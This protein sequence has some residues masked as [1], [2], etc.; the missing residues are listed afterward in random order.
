MSV[1]SI[2]HRSRAN[3]VPTDTIPTGDREAQRPAARVQEMSKGT[4]ALLAARDQAR[5]QARKLRAEQT[6]AAQSPDLREAAQKRLDSFLSE[7]NASYRVDGQEI[8]VTPAFRM[9][10]GYGPTTER[11]TAALKKALPAEV[12]RELGPRLTVI[13]NGKG[14]PKE[15]Q[16]VTQALIDGGHL[17]GRSGA[18]PRDRV[19][20]L[21]FDFGVGLDCSGFSYQ[22]HAA[23]RGAPRKLGLEEGV[24]A[25]NKSKDLRAASPGDLIVLG[26]DPGH[27]VAVYSHRSL[28]AGS[29]TPSLPGR[30]P[31]PAQFMRGGPV[32]LFEVDSSWG[33]GGKAP[34]GGVSREVWLFNEST[35]TWGY[36]DGLRG[37]AFTESKKGA[38][39]HTIVGLFGV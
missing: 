38:Y 36:F 27:K 8:R 2:A 1:A 22:A 20:Q 37:G 23:A 3:Q 34:L 26:G 35:K 29:A 5:A 9:Q 28:P 39:G 24:P 7:A 4:Q 17:A 33:A 32:H 15:I 11:A 19:R 21:M 31:V 18:S 10:G 6:A 30:P 13:A 16:R 14:T 25:P 12:V